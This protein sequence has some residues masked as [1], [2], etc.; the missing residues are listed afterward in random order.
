VVDVKF[1]KADLLSPSVSQGT[2]VSFVSAVTPDGRLQA[3][4]VAI[5]ESGAKRATP[6]SG[7]GGEFDRPIKQPRVGGGCGTPWG[8]VAAGRQQQYSPVDGERLTGVVRSY[9]PNSGFGFITCDDMPGDIY[10]GKAV[11][12]PD[13][14]LM[15][16]SGRMVTFELTYA[17]DGKL[18]SRSVELA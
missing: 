15:E 10:F 5:D 12:P 13:M 14:H 2:S 4:E 18:R 9:I 17:S 6:S 8:S 7:F 16:L 3:R 1:S 11:M